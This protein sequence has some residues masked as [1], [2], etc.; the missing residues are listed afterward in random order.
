MLDKGE[1]MLGFFQS[2]D[3]RL[4]NIRKAGSSRGLV[5]RLNSG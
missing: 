3:N 4:F 5:V 1:E 2:N